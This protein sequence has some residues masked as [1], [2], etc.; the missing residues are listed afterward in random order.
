MS[1]GSRSC[2]REPLLACYLP[3]NVAVTDFSLLIVTV[4]VSDVPLQAPLHPAKDP[5][6]LFVFAVNATVVPLANVA[7][8]PEPHAMPAGAL[9][10]EPGPLV[11][12]FNA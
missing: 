4:Q 1:S 7:V 8:Q 3:L 12:T 5:L 6:W 10:T 2:S 11:F 9:V